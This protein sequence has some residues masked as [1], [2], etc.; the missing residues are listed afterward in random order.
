MPIGEYD[1]E[2]EDYLEIKRRY[3]RDMEGEGEF[4][5]MVLNRATLRLK[6]ISDKVRAT[7]DQ[8]WNETSLKTPVQLRRERCC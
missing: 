2:R 4:A 6:N 3:S 5:A 1:E 8:K 7:L